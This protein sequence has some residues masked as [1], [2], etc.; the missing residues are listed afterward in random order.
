MILKLT[1]E[2]TTQNTP[3]R[4]KAAMSF[5]ERFAKTNKIVKVSKAECEALARRWDFDGIDVG[6]LEA[7]QAHDCEPKRKGKKEV[8]GFAFLL[9]TH[10]AN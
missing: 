3:T 10:C 9:S 6:L 5:D 8:P 2:S 1:K 7:F 4:K